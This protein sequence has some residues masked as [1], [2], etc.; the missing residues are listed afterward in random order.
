MIYSSLI[1]SCLIVLHSEWP[2]LFGVLAIL[3]AIGLTL[4]VPEIKTF[5]FA[6]SIDLN[7]VAHS[8]SPH[9]DLHQFLYSLTL[10]HSERPKLYL[11]LAFLSAIRLNSHYATAWTKLL[12]KFGRQ[13]FWCFFLFSGHFKCWHIFSSILKVKV[14]SYRKCYYQLKG[15][16]KKLFFIAIFFL[17]LIR[18]NSPFTI[19]H[20]W[21]PLPVSST[22]SL[23]L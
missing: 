15:L 9:L 12:L 18:V 1:F 16:L 8:E 19:D 7:E 2:K 17:S 13:R 6:N 21:L 23:I 22:L 11:I 3:S 14:E 20:S 5:E 10:L 4:I